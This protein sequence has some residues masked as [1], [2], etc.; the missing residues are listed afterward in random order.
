MRMAGNKQTRTSK[1]YNLSQSASFQQA[2]RSRHCPGNYL[3]IK[4]YLFFELKI[5]IIEILGGE[6]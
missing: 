3:L 5:T 1:K 4:I 6:P 2:A